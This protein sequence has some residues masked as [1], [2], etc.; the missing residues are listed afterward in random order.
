MLR[1][2]SSRRSVVAI[3]TAF[4]WIEGTR[5]CLIL[6][7][8]TV[9]QVEQRFQ[10]WGVDSWEMAYRK[11]EWSGSCHDQRTIQMDLRDGEGEITYKAPSGIS[12][13]ELAFENSRSCRHL[14]GVKS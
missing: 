5:G 13:D 14:R 3:I 8:R 11:V 2:L 12:P 10:R 6:D 9:L 7:S 1:V 4:G